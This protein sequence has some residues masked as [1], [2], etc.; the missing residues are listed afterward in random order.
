MLST[1]T[2]SSVLP[3]NLKVI[4]IWIDKY[5]ISHDAVEKHT[6]LI[7][8]VFINNNSTDTSTIKIFNIDNKSVL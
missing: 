3:S 6:N 7:R 2:T 5:K 4:K 1:T 8:N